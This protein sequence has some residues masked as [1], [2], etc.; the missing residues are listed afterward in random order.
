MLV[1]EQM[2]SCI[3]NIYIE[4][5]HYWHIFI[6]IAIGIIFIRYFLSVRFNFKFI[7]IIWIW[8]KPYA[9]YNPYLHKKWLLF[10]SL[11]CFFLFNFVD[12]ILLLIYRRIPPPFLFR[13]NL[14]G[15]QKPCIENWEAGKD[16]YQFLS[17]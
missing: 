10:G 17:P 8:E 7:W 2:K 12:I 4:I 16:S 1:A 5:S 15:V 13:S 11:W 6:I 14:N 3:L 9:I